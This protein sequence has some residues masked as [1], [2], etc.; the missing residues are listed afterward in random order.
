M[1]RGLLYV[2]IEEGVSPSPIL[3]CD[4]DCVCLSLAKSLAHAWFIVLFCVCVWGGCLFVCF[5]C[6]FVFGWLVLVWFGLVFCHTSGTWKFH[7]QGS[8]L[9]HCSNSTTALT[10]C[11]TGKHHWFLLLSAF[12]LSSLSLILLHGQDHRQDMIQCWS[13]GP[14]LDPRKLPQPP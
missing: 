1:R 8:N 5:V 4:C 11:A 14:F 12:L 2:Q 13:W 6:L 10:H 7:G 3:G 9:S